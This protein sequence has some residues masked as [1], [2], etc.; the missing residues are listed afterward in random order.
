MS[1]YIITD[2]IKEKEN[3]YKIGLTN[4]SQKYILNTYTRY[5]GNPKIK[6]FKEIPF[7]YYYENIQKSILK[8]VQ[9]YR[10]HNNNN[11]MSEWVKLPLPEILQIVNE[12]LDDSDS[13]SEDSDSE[14][15]LEYEAVPLLSTTHTKYNFTCY[16][17]KKEFQKQLQ[18]DQHNN[19]KIQCDY[20]CIAN[21]Q[22]NKII[23][24]NTYDKRILLKLEIQL[25]EVKLKQKEKDIIIEKLKKSR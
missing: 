15:D 5:L 1:I 3:M 20:V 9:K 24:L 23:N 11:N 22:A 4:K 12:F 10:I 18:L 25:E 21:E 19:N 7:K 6:F 14:S 8:R 2:P 17:C 13:N 16:K